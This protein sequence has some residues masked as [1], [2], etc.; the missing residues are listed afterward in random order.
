MRVVLNA[1]EGV[2]D[3]VAGRAGEEDILCAQQWTAPTRGTEIL[4]PALVDMLRILGQKPADVRQWASVAGPGSFTGVRLTL[5]TVA[6]IRRATGA[7]VAGLDYMQ[8]LACTAQ[9]VTAHTAASGHIWVLTHARRDLV[10]CQAFAR[11]GGDMP[12]PLAAVELMAPAEA[13]QRMLVS[14]PG[15]V[16]LG[17]GVARNA[18]ALAPALAVLPALA[19]TRPDARDL[20][21]LAGQA[22]YSATDVEPLY[23]RPCDAVDNLNH[24]AQK[25]GM[26]PEAAHARLAELLA[27]TPTTQV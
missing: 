2:L 10:H 11:Q 22:Q 23:I 18:E 6:A 12:R 24:I 17:S 20:W 3:M 5:T 19:E 8:A 13:A 4:A 25:Q 16:V 27:A 9:R 21:R 14:P 1:A 15:S 7:V 26:E